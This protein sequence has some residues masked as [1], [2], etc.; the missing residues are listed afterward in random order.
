MIVNNLIPF[1]PYDAINL[2]GL[3]FIR[4]D[5][6]VNHSPEYLALVKN[7]EAIHSAQGRELLWIGFYIIYLF[8]WLGRL[9]INGRRAYDMLSFE[10]EAY[11]HEKDKDYLKTRKHFA[12]WRKSS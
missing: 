6:A 5:S 12:Q 11:Q 10:R 8:E 3:V 7:H 9:V 2:F 1:R 4:K